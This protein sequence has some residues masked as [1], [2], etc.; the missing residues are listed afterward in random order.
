MAKTPLV[1]VLSVLAAS[2]LGAAGQ[3]LFKEAADRSGSGTFAFLRSPLVPAGIGCY[4]TVMFLF[5]YSFKRGGA[6]TVL[7]PIY[8]TT[9]VWAAVIGYAF[10]RQPIRPIHVLG[11]VL[12]IAGMYLMGLGKAG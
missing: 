12:L 4:L 6:V 2:V 8:A 7:Y 1:A 3:Y 10:Y 11:M 5:T 9:F